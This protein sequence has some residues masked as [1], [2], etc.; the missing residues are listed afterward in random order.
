MSTARLQLLEGR[1]V[2][3]ALRDGIRMD[4]CQLVSA[5]RADTTTLWLFSN[6]ADVFIRLADVIDVWETAAIGRAA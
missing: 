6:G 2:S 1:Q 5:G 3:V 4:D